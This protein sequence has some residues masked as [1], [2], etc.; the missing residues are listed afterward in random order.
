MTGPWWYAWGGLNQRLFLD[1]NH[2]GSGW[3]WDHLA[4]WGTLAGDHLYYP[5][6]AALA[7]ALAHKRPNLLGQRAVLCF[8]VAYLFDWLLVASIKPWLNFPRPP[9]ALGMGAVHVIGRPELFHSFPSGHSAFAFTAMAS[10]LPGSHWAL[11]GLLVVYA[12]WVAWSRMAVGAH[13]PADVLGGALIGMFSAWL[14]SQVLD[15]TG[16]GRR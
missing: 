5:L 11:R 6:W 1:I 16:Y 13:F 8:L 4:A 3:L 15:W 2:A 14:A 10:L 9:L 12:F 7:L